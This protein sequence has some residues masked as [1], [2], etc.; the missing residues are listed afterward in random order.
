MKPEPT[1]HPSHAV[2]PMEDDA[3]A[4]RAWELL[5]HASAPEI[6]PGFAARVAATAAEVPQD[7][8]PSVIL[9]FARLGLP[10]AAAAALMLSLAGNLFSPARTESTGAVQSPP[11]ATDSSANLADLARMDAA[12][13]LLPE[14]LELAILDP[15]VLELASIDDPSQITEDHILGLL[16]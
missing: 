11:A 2:P 7:P 15:G 13:S 10:L 12:L 3:A 9:K 1:S 14:D 5:G 16:Y 6:S 8:R 4:R